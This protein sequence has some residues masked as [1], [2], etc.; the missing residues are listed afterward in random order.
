MI[1]NSKT[2]KVVKVT[3]VTFDEDSSHT[4]RKQVEYTARKQSKEIILTDEEEEEQ[5]QCTRS[6]RSSTVST[7]VGQSHGQ[8]VRSSE[9]GRIS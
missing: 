6:Q 8:T 1:Y 5:E 2:N 4:L 3:V 9:S 7:L